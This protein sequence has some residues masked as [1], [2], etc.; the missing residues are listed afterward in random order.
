MD[1]KFGN[2]VPYATERN[3]LVSSYTPHPPMCTDNGEKRRAVYYVTKMVYVTGEIVIAK[4]KKNL[5][6]KKICLYCVFVRCKK[7]RTLHGAVVPGGE[8]MPAA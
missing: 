4:S 2:R 1:N 8:Y 3:N 6:T 7:V 5:F